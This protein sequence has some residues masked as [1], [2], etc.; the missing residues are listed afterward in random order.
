M[1]VCP[2]CKKSHFSTFIINRYKEKMPVQKCKICGY[3]WIF[4]EDLVRL[5]KAEAKK[6]FIDH[7]MKLGKSGSNT[8]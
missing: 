7:L 4:D 2:R 3:L 8:S 5:T 6:M 1:G